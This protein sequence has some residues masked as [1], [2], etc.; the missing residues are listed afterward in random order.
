MLSLATQAR[1]LLAFTGGF[2]FDQVPL[3]IE[4]TDP[5]P[6]STFTLP[7]PFTLDVNFNEPINPLSVQVSDLTLSGIP[8]ASVTDVSVINADLTARFTIDVSLEGVLNAKIAV[9][10]VMDTFGNPNTSQFSADYIFDGGLGAFPTPFVP[11]LPLGSLVYQS[12]VSG[13][14]GPANDTDVFEFV[15]DSGQSVSVLVE[16]ATA[17]LRPVVELRDAGGA[18]VDLA[19][20]SATGNDALLSPVTLGVGLGGTYSVVVRSSSSATSGPYTAHVTLNAAHETES[21]NGAA[22]NTI[23]T[24]QDL[25]PALLSLPEAGIVNP[26]YS[27]AAVLGRIENIGAVATHIYDLNNSFADS[28]GG[29]NIVSGGGTLGPGG[30]TFSAGQGPNL[31]NAI[32]PSTYSIEMIFRISNTTG[33]KK[34]LDFKNRSS[35]FGLYNDDREVTLFPYDSESGVV[36]TANQNAHLVVT[37][38]EAAKHFS[39][40]VNGVQRISVLDVDDAAVFSAANNIIHFLR[41]DTLFGEGENPSGFLD[42]VRIYDGVLTPT[43][44]SSLFSGG[45][46]TPAPKDWYKLNLTAGQTITIG[47]NALTSGTLSL[48]LVN[49][50]GTTVATAVAGPTNVYKLINA[51]QV[52]TSGTYGISVN[53]NPDTSYNL[54]VVRDSAF[55]LED[56]DSHT[57]A[58]S[59]TA[60]HGVLG[61]LDGEDWY[62]LNVTSLCHTIHLQT[63]TPADGPNASINT[64]NPHIE[65]YSPVGPAGTLVASGSQLGDS[66]NESIAYLPAITGVYHV[67][68][69][70]EDSTTGEYFLSKNL[71]PAV[72]SLSVTSVTTEGGTATVDGTISD[73]ESGDTHTVIISWGP[74]EG[75]TTIELAAGVSAFTPTINTWMTIHQAP[76]L[77]FIPWRS[78]SRIVLQHREQRGPPYASITQRLSLPP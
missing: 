47:I 32:H 19:I 70:A 67:R 8:G 11:T 49:S 20:A 31:S 58:Q 64:L 4:S 18:L 73:P 28:L 62:A 30:Y 48:N 26:P 44:V 38:D 57:A 16:P 55:D 75:S 45:T 5:A 50:G 29:P 43:Q 77:T 60:V 34:L 3:V 25:N 2:F 42:R 22:N 33:F 12:S 71:T 36:F 10:S 17:T 1:A 56:N 66:R 37:R 21:H 23:A 39:V 27:R 53:G 6:A 76:I 54:F 9:G 35:D 14:I 59:I 74:G 63:N 72:A 40:Y 51:F 13:A 65:L 46:P 68:I 69:L 78:L 52:S 15:V 61:H 7:G 41:D 24:A